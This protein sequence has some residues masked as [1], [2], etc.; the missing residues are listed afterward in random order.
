MQMLRI[1]DKGTMLKIT[2][3]FHMSDKITHPDIIKFLPLKRKFPE[4]VI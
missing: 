3:F 4:G 2:I 1:A